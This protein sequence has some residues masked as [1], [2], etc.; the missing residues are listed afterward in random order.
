VFDHAL[1][2]GLELLPVVML[3]S[4]AVALLGSAGP[5]RQAMRTPPI[6]SLRGN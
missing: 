6:H 2:V 3:L 4:L 1:P 5:L